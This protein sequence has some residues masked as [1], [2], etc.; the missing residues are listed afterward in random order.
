M[1]LTK[2]PHATAASLLVGIAALH[3]LLGAAGGGP[4]GVGPAA[5]SAGALPPAGSSARHDLEWC[6]QNVSIIHDVYWASACV[7]DAQ[8][9]RE[10]TAACVAPRAQQA[11]EDAP[12]PADESPDC[13]LP[14][15]RARG[16]NAARA[17]AEQQCL[18]EAGMR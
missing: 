15:D 18:A 7:V 2:H 17:K 13:T 6:L 5:P 12:E 14:E 16:L 3:G 11:C 1:R 4:G 10:R 9:Q 8:A